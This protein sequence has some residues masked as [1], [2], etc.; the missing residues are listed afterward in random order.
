MDLC[1]YQE[2]LTDFLADSFKSNLS[3][4]HFKLQSFLTALYF[5]TD[6]SSWSEQWPAHFH[7]EMR[8]RF[9]ATEVILRVQA[10]QAQTSGKRFNCFWW[11]LHLACNSDLKCVLCVVAWQSC[12]LMVQDQ[13]LCPWFLQECLIP[14]NMSQYYLISDSSIVQIYFG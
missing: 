5:A 4:Y 8:F 7:T 3:K 1:S 10:A 12:G 2:G 9:P 13:I 6:I 11:E 14:T